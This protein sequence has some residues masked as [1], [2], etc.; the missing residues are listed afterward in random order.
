M[1]Y[2]FIYS[3]NTSNVLLLVVLSIWMWL[4]SVTKSIVSMNEPC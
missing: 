2:C 3:I 1:Y 4:L